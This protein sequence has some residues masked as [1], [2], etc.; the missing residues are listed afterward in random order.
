MKLILDSSCGNKYSFLS[1][2]FLANKK[3]APTKIID[4]AIIEYSKVCEGCSKLNLASDNINE[5]YNTASIIKGIVMLF[6]LS[7]K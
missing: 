6:G 5:H 3:I 7:C 1:Y 4:T 2:L